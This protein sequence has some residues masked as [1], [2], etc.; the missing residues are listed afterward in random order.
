M[1]LP[2]GLPII[3]RSHERLIVTEKMDREKLYQMVQDGSYRVRTEAEYFNEVMKPE[4][5]H[6]TGNELYF[7][8][9]ETELFIQR[10]AT[11]TVDHKYHIKGFT[12]HIVN[13]ITEAINHSEA[14]TA[15]AKFEK[16]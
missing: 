16:L 9:S 7:A 15:I 10:N 13:T 6:V 1:K 8:N 14:L 4:G 11:Y 2:I 5:W 3:S 12:R